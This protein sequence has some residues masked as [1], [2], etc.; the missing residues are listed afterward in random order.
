MTKPEFYLLLDELMELSPGTT[1]GD[2]VL[3]THSK[4]DSLAL[5]GF[6]ALL[7]QHFGLVLPASRI[8]ECRTVAQL[9]DLAGDKVQ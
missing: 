2:D 3:A 4:W 9:A 6:I 5:I 1:R 7:D 8:T